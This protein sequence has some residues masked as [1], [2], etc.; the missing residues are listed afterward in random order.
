MLLGFSQV[1]CFEDTSILSTKNRVVIAC[2]RCSSVTDPAHCGP[3]AAASLSSGSDEPNAASLPP[4]EDLPSMP[5]HDGCVASET[6]ALHDECVPTETAPLHGECSG[7]CVSTHPATLHAGRVSVT[8][9]LAK[10]TAG[11]RKVATA[12]Q[13]SKTTMI[14]RREDNRVKRAEWDA[15]H[16]A[17]LAGEG[18]QTDPASG[19]N[20]TR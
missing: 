12:G 6:A 13:K 4:F 5:L 16:A 7:G 17:W 8:H 9:P 15:A 3:A 2:R 19:G 11:V 18:S 14:R 1:E 10:L 20:F